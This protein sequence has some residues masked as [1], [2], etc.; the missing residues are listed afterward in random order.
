ME[1]RGL[2]G[3]GRAEVPE[4]LPFRGWCPAWP[5]SLQGCAVGRGG[6]AVS[7]HPLAEASWHLVP[8]GPGKTRTVPPSVRS[9]PQRSLHPSMRP[10][11]LPPILPAS[12]PATHPWGGNNNDG[13]TIADIHWALIMCRVLC[14][15]NSSSR[16]H[17]VG[18]VFLSVSWMSKLSFLEVKPLAQD[19]RAGEGWR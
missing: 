2:L 4:T 6:G 13:I 1:V 7:L 14:H 16:L 19:Y 15:P 10:S 8:A 12:Q 3:Q 5:A 9:S 18:T 17:E 11:I